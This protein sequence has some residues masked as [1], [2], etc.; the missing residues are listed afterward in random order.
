MGT[1]AVISIQ[2]RSWVMVRSK[3]S[4]LM[5]KGKGRKEEGVH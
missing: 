2:L 5:K 1:A 3:G 4:E